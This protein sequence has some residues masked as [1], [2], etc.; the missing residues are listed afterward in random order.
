[1]R[2]GLGMFL[3]TTKAIVGRRFGSRAFVARTFAAVVIMSLMWP[4][5]QSKG[6]EVPVVSDDEAVLT[7]TVGPIDNEIYRVVPPAN[8]A[9][10][11]TNALWNLRA[12]HSP[13][14][15]DLHLPQSAWVPGDTDANG[16]QLDQWEMMHPSVVYVPEGYL[17]WEYWLA[18]TP[19]N[20]GANGENPCLFVSHDNVQ[21]SEVVIGSDTLH[22]PVFTAHDFMVTYL[23]DCE[24]VL[25]DN[26]ELWL[27]FRGKKQ[28]FGGVAD[29][30]FV[31]GAYTVNGVSWQGRN[32]AA[33]PLSKADTLV[34]PVSGPGYLNRNGFIVRK[35]QGFD[36]LS[37]A[38]VRVT[39]GRY[40]MWTV[41]T[42]NYLWEGEPGDTHWVGVPNFVTLWEAP[43]LGGPWD[44]VQTCNWLSSDPALR[45]IWHLSVLEYGTDVYLAFVTETSV[46]AY[47]SPASLYLA[48]S[49]DTG[50]SFAPR[51]L[52]L[53]LPVPCPHW[54]NQLIYRSFGILRPGPA[55]TSIGLYYSA[56]GGT[57][58]DTLDNQGRWAIGFT[59][60]I[61]QQSCQARGNVD[62]IVGP[63]GPVDIADLVQ[64]VSY[65]FQ[66]G[67]VLPSTDEGN[68]DGI[69]GPS[70][71]VD[72]ADLTYLIS[73]LF[74]GGY[75]PPPCF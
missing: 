2:V 59:E 62:G 60:C 61:T 58:D 3:L 23:S 6:D 29:T 35:A 70:G 28:T 7:M 21:W 65:L 24:L 50:K 54:A 74:A 4:W 51:P 68:V 1:M 14:W 64:L 36:L 31:F 75:P 9:F 11:S 42:G 20:Q 27:I 33:A 16:F 38:V 63:E 52:P 10:D 39:S 46:G 37:P 17:G 48:L 67:I 13:T 30:N 57:G 47:G 18:G 55:D 71:P 53:L 5:S 49:S 8:L 12:T 34:G 22:N 69:S 32:E 73:Y 72:V 19:L 15:L 44:T 66:C 43:A 26:G 41:E 25:A 40:R 45:E 56:Y